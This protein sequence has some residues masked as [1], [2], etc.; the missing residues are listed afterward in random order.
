M[1]CLNVRVAVTQA[2]FEYINSVQLEHFCRGNLT[3]KC[4]GFQITFIM[5]IIDI[6][7]ARYHK[8]Y[9]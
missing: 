1:F 4:S 2:N 8:K 6:H 7:S 9:F 5:K 3:L